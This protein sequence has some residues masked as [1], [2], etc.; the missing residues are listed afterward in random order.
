MIFVT[1]GTQFPF[2]RLVEIIDKA[3]PQ[4]GGEEV[5]V[6]AMKGKYEPANLKLKELIPADEFSQIMSQCRLVI[7]HAGIGAI[8]SSMLKSKPIIIFPRKAELG[9][10]R[11]NHQIDTAKRFEELGYV[12]VAWDNEQLEKMLFD[13]PTKSLYDLKAEASPELINH[14]SQ[15]IEE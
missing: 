9:E 3:A 13:P 4:L 8:L 6:Q 12:N 14:V 7:A 1:A 11:N 15:F 5:V 10:H 2:D